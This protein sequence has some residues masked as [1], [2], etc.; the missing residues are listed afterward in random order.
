M[1]R[2]NAAKERLERMLDASGDVVEAFLDGTRKVKCPGC[3]ECH[4]VKFPSQAS[5]KA[6]LAVYDRVGLG[7][8]QTVHSTK[9]KAKGSAPEQL[10][11]L[12]KDLMELPYPDRLL[13][14]RAILPEQ[15]EVSAQLASAARVDDG[16]SR[17]AG[18]TSLPDT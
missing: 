7:T 2:V 11:E 9:E 6:A 8:H 17:E 10:Q 4:E 13:L 16:A 1:R 12:V 15:D 5:L 18:R 14:S 3:G